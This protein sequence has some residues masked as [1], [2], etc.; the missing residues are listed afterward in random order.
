MSQDSIHG[1]PVANQILR[2][3]LLCSL[4]SYTCCWLICQFPNYVGHRV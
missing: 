1:P 2:A 4:A 3:R